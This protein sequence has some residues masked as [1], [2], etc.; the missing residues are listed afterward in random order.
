MS[1]GVHASC[2]ISQCVVQWDKGHAC[3]AFCEGII[4]SRWSGRLCVF[5]DERPRTCGV[6]DM[7]ES[8]GCF[9]VHIRTPRVHVPAFPDSYLPGVYIITESRTLYL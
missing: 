2:V 4:E 1:S 3:C 5:V 9:G 7:F 8:I 6:E